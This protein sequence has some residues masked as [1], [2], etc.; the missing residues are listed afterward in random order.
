[1]T[2]IPL[3]LRRLRSSTIYIS[4]TIQPYK[5]LSLLLRI[6]Y[7]YINNKLVLYIAIKALNDIAGLNSLVPTLL[8]EN[9]SVITTPKELF[10]ELDY[11]EIES[12]ITGDTFKVLTYNL[13]IYKGRIFNLRLPYEKSRLVFAGHSDK[14]KKEILTQLI[15]AIGPSL[16][17]S[18]GMHC[19]LRDITQAYFK[20]YYN[21][22]KDKLRMETSSYNLCLLITHEGMTTIIITNFAIPLVPLIIYMDLRSLYKCLV[23]L[24]SYEKREITEIRWINSKDNLVDT[25]IK[26]ALN[27]TLKKLILYN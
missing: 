18:Y 6:I 27:F 15:L 16:M 13:S 22:H 1:M 11:I 12:L 23:K 10:K 19:E 5:D 14:E 9:D 24:K 4:Y 2:L 20:T 3:Y 7:N 26:K 17:A 8:L 21:H 25:Y